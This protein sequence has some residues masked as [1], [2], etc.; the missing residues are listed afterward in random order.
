MIK[1]GRFDALPSTVQIP[2]PRVSALAHRI[3]EAFDH[4]DGDIPAHARVRD[5]LPVRELRSRVAVLPAAY[6]EAL[7]HHTEYTCTALRDLLPEGD[8]HASLLLVVLAAVRVATVDHQTPLEPRGFEHLHGLRDILS[9]IVRFSRAAAEDDMTVEIALRCDD[10]GEA[11]LGD[12][13]EVVRVASRSDCLH[14]DLDRAACTVLE[15][16]R[17]GQP[18]CE[19]AVH[20]AL[21]SG[22]GTRCQPADRAQQAR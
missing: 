6:E 5:A 15:A 4:R 12:R 18:A 1:A 13:E 3:G 16:H 21:K 10:G 8:R 2:V 17:H 19:L 14:G 22:R 7:E 20:L 9:V 11:L